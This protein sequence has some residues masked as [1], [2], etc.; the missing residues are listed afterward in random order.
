VDGVKNFQTGQPDIL[1]VVFD[2]ERTDTDIIVRALREGNFKVKG[3]PVYLKSFPGEP[4][5]K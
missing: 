1:I 2:D 5:S 4:Q 3:K